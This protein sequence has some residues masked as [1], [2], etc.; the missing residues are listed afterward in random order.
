[1]VELD[2][3]THVAAGVL[4]ALPFIS[5]TDPISTLGIIGSIAP[6]WDKVLKI[7]HRTFTHCL[8]SLCGSCMYMSYINEKLGIVWFITYSSHLFL[9]SLTVRGV[10]LLYP[11]KKDTYGLK[12]FT[13]GKK[14]DKCLELACNF[15][16]AL[17]IISKL[18]GTATHIINKLVTVI[19]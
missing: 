9:D 19:K 2:T 10:P 13:T 7:K 8:I 15:G 17:Y 1:M 14:F 12:L 11:F 5:M 16:S 18:E 3:K 6:D 4:V